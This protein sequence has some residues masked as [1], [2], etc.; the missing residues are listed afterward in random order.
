MFGPVLV[1]HAG[2]QPSRDRHEA[3]PTL[4]VEY[5]HSPE[6]SEFITTGCAFCRAHGSDNIR[7]HEGSYLE[8]G[9]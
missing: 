4:P 8:G 2:T 5:A 9:T 3:L 7:V 6:A 1:T